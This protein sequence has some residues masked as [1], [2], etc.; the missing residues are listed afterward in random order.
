[1]SRKILNACV[2]VAASLLAYPGSATAA[3]Y[4]QDGSGHP[5]TQLGTRETRAIVLVFLASDCPIS[6]RYLPELK[7]LDGEFAH[8]NVAFWLIY[9]NYGETAKAVR[10]HLAEFGISTR[11]LLKPSPD[12]MALIPATITPE[13]AILTTTVGHDGNQTLAK[14]YLGRIDN[15]YVEIGRERPAATEHDLEQAIRAVLSQK[16]AKKADGP[17]VG[18]GIVSRP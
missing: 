10:E 4:G 2:L 15:R 1:M 12:L 17:P 18:C 16:S 7:R 9:P 6:N 3:T 13:A 8:Q 14:A 11:V 5:V